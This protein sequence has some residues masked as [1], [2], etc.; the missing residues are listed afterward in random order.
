MTAGVRQAAFYFWDAD[1]QEVIII[2]ID[3]PERNWILYEA[4][5]V[6]AGCHDGE[7]RYGMFT[8]KDEIKL[9]DSRRRPSRWVHI[10]KEDFPKEFQAYLLI[11]G[12]H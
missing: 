7:D 6:D 10:P 2:D 9:R 8:K 4:P 1:K 12:V 11:M 3:N 5:C